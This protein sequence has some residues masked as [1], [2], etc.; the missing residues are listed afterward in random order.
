MKKLTLAAI[1]I[2]S[3][4]VAGS[5]NA[6]M[7]YLNVGS[8]DYDV[9]PGDVDA[10]F[11]TDTF[12]SFNYNGLLATSLYDYSDGSIF[13]DFFDT[14]ISNELSALGIP[15]SGTALDGS[16]TVALVDPGCSSGAGAI[17]SN[18]QCDL[19]ALN[20]LVPPF[21]GKDAEGFLLTW[22]FQTQ[23]R[24]EG[25]L[26]PSGPQYTSGY[27]DIYFND[28]AN[29]ANDR[30][31]FSA[32]VINSSI[33][34]ADLQINFEITEAEAGFMFI[35][36]GGSFQDAN[37]AI[38]SGNLPLLTLNSNVVPPVPTDDQLLLVNG[39]AVRQS[40]LNGQLA[41]R[42]P[43]PATIAILGLGLLGF[44]AASRR[45]Q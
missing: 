18:A 41:A 14:N 19:D 35:Q 31:V 45:K 26:T 7:V 13:G 27:L 38:A 28:F 32:S 6:N 37:A 17:V 39:F 4:F 9:I 15:T 36:N 34:L 23:Y 29:D 12:T 8:N 20:P 44:G 42:I 3:I 24:F 30:K 10:D 43:E 25:T 21:S 11:V 2:A 40:E 22:D 16:S 5:V 33:T 1:T